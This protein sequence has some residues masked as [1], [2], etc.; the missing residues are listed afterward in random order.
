MAGRD[1]DVVVIGGGI[2]GCA[3]AYYLAKRATRVTLLE[4]GEIA[5]EQS[6][7]AWGFVRK[8]GRHPAEVPLMLV[9]SPMWGD[10]D[11]ELQADVEFVRGGNLAL[12]ETRADLERLE[13]IHAADRQAGLNTRLVSPQELEK[14]V[15][16]IRREWAGGLFSP[17]DGHAE[18]RK[19]TEAFARAAGRAGARIETGCAALGLDLTNDRISG[20]LTE[21][22][23]IRTG[24]V[25]CAAGIWSPVVARWA[26]LSLPCQVVATS[27]AATEPVGPVTAAG[28][29]G[30]YVAYRQTPGGSI[31][32]GDGYRGAG[33]EHEVTLDSFRHLRLF[34]RNFLENR[35]S[36]HV[37]VG[38][39]L[40]RDVCLAVSGRRQIRRREHEPGPARWQIGFNLRH[41]RAELPGLADLKIQRCWAGYID[42]AP[43]LIPVLG[44][45]DR[46][47]GFY[48]ATNFTG[49]GFAMAPVAGKLLA[50]AI[51]DSRPS[52][53]LRP[54]RFSR[55]AE[56]DL[57]PARQAF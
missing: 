17:D 29:W 57:A 7:R 19:A 16:G 55:F 23:P 31:Y 15:T 37:R 41:L 54:F 42:L 8:Q 18:P 52:L 10:L 1:A 35:E 39:P 26:G 34:Y 6:S 30:P 32:I 40:L 28:V 13:A 14:I 36:L 2:V 9:A 51:L 12:A 4:K 25:V 5:G 21:R 43:D 49:H 22:G 33:S 47:A 56:G 45:V 50:E 24:V 44:P 27:V 48:L 11:R 3:T 46:P 20:V 53:D 38:R